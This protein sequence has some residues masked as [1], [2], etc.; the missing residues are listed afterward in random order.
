[1]SKLVKPYACPCVEKIIMDNEIS[2]TMTSTP[3]EDP[4]MTLGPVDELSP[5]LLP[6]AF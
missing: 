5:E 1:M 6:V 2:L 4:F 3:W